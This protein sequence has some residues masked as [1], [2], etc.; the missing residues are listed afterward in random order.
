MDK[1]QQILDAI[2]ELHQ[3]HPNW[4]FGQLVAN[5]SFFAK[6]PL[7]SAVWDVEDDEFLKAAQEHLAH[8]QE[9]EREIVAA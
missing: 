2:R 3:Q 6:G 7:K 5:V 8:V 4:R 9:K 1:T